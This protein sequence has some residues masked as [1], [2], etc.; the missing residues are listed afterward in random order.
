MKRILLGLAL[1]IPAASVWAQ[2]QAQPIT[3]GTSQT[4]MDAPEKNS[5]LE[6]YT[7][8]PMVRK[9]AGSM[10]ISTNRA[11]R[12]F[13]DFNSG[14]LLLVVGYYVFKLVPGRLRAKRKAVDRELAEARAATADAQ[15][16]L[17]QAETQLRALGGEVEV[18]KR[19]A[20]EGA[21]AERVRMQAALDEEKGRIAH[22]ADNEVAAVQAGAERGLRRFVADLAVQRAADRVRLTPEDDQ[23]MV[24]GFL[25]ELA[26]QLGKQG[27]N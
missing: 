19:Q 20:S 14:V 17:A 13:E 22:Q 25:R 4:R 12:Y 9:L 10:G 7:H 26:G 6:A 8:A 5:E 18:L 16:R 3:N 15:R 1:A 21:E 27:R 23:A 11:S 24:D 2:T